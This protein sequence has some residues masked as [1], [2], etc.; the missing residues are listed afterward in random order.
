MKSKLV[1]ILLILTLLTGCWDERLL[2]DVRTVYLSGFDVDEKQDYMITVLIRN[3][4]IGKSSRGERS[5]SNKMVIGRGKSIRETSL[6][7][8]QGVAGIFDPAKGRTLI[9]G[10]E[11]AKGDIYNV[12]DSTYR[13]PRVNVNAKVVVTTGS[14][15]KLIQHLTKKEMEKAEYFYELIK[16]SEDLTEIP[17][18]TAQTVCTYLFDEGRDF[19]LPHLGIDK[20]EHTVKVK[21]TALFHDRSFTGQYLSIDESTLLLLFLDQRAKEAI[22][23]D[24]VEPQ[25]DGALSYKVKKVSK[26]LKVA[27][28]DK[29]SVDISL[30]LDVEVIDYPKDHLDD[31]KRIQDL[32]QRLSRQMT[33]N[34]EALFKKLADN[35]SDILGLGRELIAFY[36]SIWEEIKGKNY[37]KHIEVNPK[38][39]INIIDSGII[40]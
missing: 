12:L 36:P 25:A 4:N 2:K 11:I 17:S 20:K 31:K 38:V 3:L 39:K 6:N 15:K 26:N 21:G 9:L 27:K 40:L 1:L 18:V 35:Q 16:S 22:L 7:I 23:T 19:F 37:Y 14:A 28:K 24:H 13:D 8:D 30:Q 34:A 32:N 33:K 5:I 29:V 10:N